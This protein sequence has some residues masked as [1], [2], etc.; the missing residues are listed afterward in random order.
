MISGQESLTSQ[1]PEV[2]EG[3]ASFEKAAKCIRDLF[4]EHDVGSG[5][6]SEIG[7][8][9]EALG[10]GPAVAVRSSATAEDSRDASFAGQ[11]ETHLN[12]S[13]AQALWSMP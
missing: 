2:V 11:H 3:A 6:R 7:A 9:Y 13:G 12:V 8:A 1:S 5:I 4:D 10:D